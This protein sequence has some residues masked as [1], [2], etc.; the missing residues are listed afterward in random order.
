MCR[1]GTFSSILLGSEPM[2]SWDV[3]L[4]LTETNRARVRVPHRAE[5]QPHP[6][7]FSVVGWWERWGG[8]RSQAELGFLNCVSQGSFCLGPRGARAEPFGYIAGRQ[9]HTSLWAQTVLLQ[10]RRTA[11][12]LLYGFRHHPQWETVWICPSKSQIPHSA[13]L[14]SVGGGRAAQTLDSQSM[15]PL[16]AIFWNMDKVLGHLLQPGLASP[17]TDSFDLFS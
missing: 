1:A 2:Q 12:P 15:S 16:E 8:V 17:T 7:W 9:I 3:W 6:T 5:L 4:Y 13:E 10:R 11:W 14:S